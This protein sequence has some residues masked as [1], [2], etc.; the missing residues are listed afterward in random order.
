LSTLKQIKRL[1]G[2]SVVYGIAG[3]F[4]RFVSL[5]LFPFYSRVLL[6]NEYGVLG[7]YNATFFFLFLF[8][9]FS[10]DSAAYRFYFDSDNSSIQH[11]KIISN[12]FLFQLS[13]SIGLLIFT[14]L[15]A[16]FLS[17]TLFGAYP[18]PTKLVI[19]M[20]IAILLY[21]VPNIMEAFYRLQR[22]P[23]GAVV[24]TLTTAGL[25]IL[26][27]VI[28]ILKFHLGVKG[29]VYGQLGGYFVGSIYG[30]FVL[31]KWI[32]FSF[33]N[34][35][36][37]KEMLRYS[38]PLVPATVAS[39]ALIFFTNYYLKNKLDFS[40]LGLYNIG[41][42]LASA[43]GL[44][45]AAFGQAWSPFAFSIANEK[46][47]LRTYSA[48]FTVYS[49]FFSFICLTFSVFLP[50][51]LKVLA[52]HNY[53]DAEIVGTILCYNL[54]FISTS[55][56]GMTGC[57]IVKRTA[58]YAKAVVLAAIVSSVL[59]MLL[60]QHFGK[61]GAAVGILIG[62]LIIPI[63]VFMTSQRYYRI[64]YSFSKTIIIIAS[65]ILFTILSKLFIG[66]GTLKF[67]ALKLFILLL[68]ALISFT[69]IRD[70]FKTFFWSIKLKKSLAKN[71]SLE[72]SIDIVR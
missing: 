71:E 38:L 37:L 47:S 63:T 40:Q 18:E 5:F 26:I 3:I 53:Y 69:I 20:G 24:F 32:K 1:V 33:F 6:P 12:W 21:A 4:T 64:P 30:L 49:L 70:D 8:A 48:V 22:K 58:P 41:N 52:T 2:E 50:D 7:M 35:H 10:M 66:S 34:I 60:S 44:L 68:F 31:R 23:I 25:S 28:C 43:I 14:I 29:F 54:F 16:T 42:I 57:G 19:W 59:M 39:Q 11:K 51:I 62:Q 55:I 17:R 36:L 56:I 15:C 13:V 27:S 46:T 9:T 72:N 65:S 67:V 61:E 45:T